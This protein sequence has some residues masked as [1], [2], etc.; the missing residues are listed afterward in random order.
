MPNMNG[1]E[2]S[3]K[4]RELDR[5]EIINLSDTKIYMHSAISS[6]MNC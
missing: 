1:L 6:V 2:A 5:E 4:L 3:K